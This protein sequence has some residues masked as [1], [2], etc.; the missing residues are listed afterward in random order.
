[1][2]VTSYASTDTDPRG[3]LLRPHLVTRRPAGAIFES[4]DPLELRPGEQE[5]STRNEEHF[6][7]G[8]RPQPE[9]TERLCVADESRSSGSTQLAAPS[10]D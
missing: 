6:R 4:F 9:D 1:V 8:A 5:F 3:N 10:S 7:T 2:A